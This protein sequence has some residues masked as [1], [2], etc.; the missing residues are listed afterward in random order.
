MS[1]TCQ[2]EPAFSTPAQSPEV[3]LL[4][5]E[6]KQSP[7]VAMNSEAGGERDCS[8][9]DVLEITGEHRWCVRGMAWRRSPDF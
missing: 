7:C 9:L 3:V 8:P 5:R 6:L 2:E 1:K 4:T